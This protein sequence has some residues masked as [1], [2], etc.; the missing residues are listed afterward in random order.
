MAN[1]TFLVNDIIQATENDSTEFVDYIPK[2]VNRAEER[3]T[4]MLDDVGLVEISAVALSATRN[5]FALPTGTRVIKNIFIEENG[6]KINLLPRT[7]EYINDY[8]PVSASTGTPRYYSRQT[9][10]SIYFAP[11]ASATYSGKI[12]FTKRPTTLT[13]ATNTNYFTDFCY[14][15]LYYASMVEAS[16]FMK[17]Y[18]VTP[19]YE[20]QFQAAILSLANQARRTRRD[21][22]Q[23]P[24]SP[25]GADTGIIPP[26]PISRIN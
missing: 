1:Y 26:T 25:A 15:A 13:S 9:N 5:K 12:V 7:D 20:E 8:W 2:I 6:T 10:T 21:D 24:S 3:L 19:I 4:K 18:S 16:N 23:S 14:D 22:M 11:T 17:N